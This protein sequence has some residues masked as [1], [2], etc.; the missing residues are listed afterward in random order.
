[1]KK[2][3]ITFLLIL[4]LFV[5]SQGE[6]NNWYFGN[7][8]ALN[9]S[10][11][12]PQ[13]IT[14][15]QMSSMISSGS[16]S[17]SN[18]NLLFYTDGNQ[19]W[20]RDHQFMSNGDIQHAGSQTAIVKHPTNA[21]L[22]YIFSSDVTT[23]NGYFAYY[24]VVDMSLGGLMNG[25]PLGAVSNLKKIPILNEFGNIFNNAKGVTVV[26]HGD[27]NSFWVL[28][29][30]DSKVYSY[31]LNSQGLSN[32]PIVNNLI[33]SGNNTFPHISFIKASPNINTCSNFTNFL[34]VSNIQGYNANNESI[35]YS[36]NNFSGLITS[37]FTLSIAS[38]EP[39]YL[40]F[41]Q[42]ANIL[43]A[44]KL[45]GNL[46]GSMFY[47]VDLLNSTNNNL[48]YTSVPN[49]QVNLGTTGIIT[50]Q[51]NKKGDIYFYKPYNDTEKYLGQIINPDV[52][53]QSYADLYAIYFSNM[54]SNAISVGSRN[55]LP[56]LVPNLSESTS[57]YC[58]ASINLSSQENNSSHT[59]QASQSIVAESNYSISSGK[60][61]IMKA[62]NNISLLPNTYI[63]NGANFLAKIEDCNCSENVGKSKNTA[64]RDNMFLDLRNSQKL[65]EEK[66][67]MGVE[68]YPNPTS[69]IL[70]IK[71][72]SKIESI[73]VVGVDG[74]TFNVVLNE[75]K[76]DVID[77][78]S[79]VYIIN[80]ETKH[81]IFKKKFIKK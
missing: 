54:P 66:N 3:Y 7:M 5:F 25:Q 48:I 24:S 52:Y 80:I 1:M 53:G 14:N 45:Q 23:N 41:N 56:Q 35:I 67:I 51:R 17:D 10:N 40:E 29:L 70:N 73:S 50:L 2:F 69:D 57:Y 28:V 6:N 43:Y 61:I 49:A 18:G 19:V 65:Y 11:S 76:I 38:L 55:D 9:F 60:N 8:A 26:P 47:S 81:G 31:N 79:G 59:Y 58:L 46:V 71:T 78:P 20:N 13:I 72:N 75:N 63:E 16:V 15:S 34:S 21:D 44:G 77:L 33:T 74:K 62:G 64:Q 42:Y 12:N 39:L 27:N 36:F 37:D 22:Y 68:I 4:P 32:T 30:T